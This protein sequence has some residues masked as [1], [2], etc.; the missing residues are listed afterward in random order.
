[1]RKKNANE[2]GIKTQEFFEMV[3]YPYPLPDIRRPS[4]KK[5]G[6]EDF[7]SDETWVYMACGVLGIIQNKQKEEQKINAGFRFVL[8]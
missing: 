2:Q 8:G 4:Y 3:S 6:L 7:G 5:Y 1:V